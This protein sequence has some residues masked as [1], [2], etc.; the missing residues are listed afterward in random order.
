MNIPPSLIAGDAMS[1]T[2]VSFTRPDSSVV[3]SAAGWVLTYSLRGP[4][5]AGIDLPGVPQGTGWKFTLTA[6]QSAPFNTGSSPLTWYWQASATLGADR[7]TAGRGTLVVN[8]NL[9][10]IGVTDAFD[11]RSQAEVILAAID[12]E[13]AA[14]LNNGASIEYTI[15]TRSLKKEPMSELLKLRSE[16]LLRV[17]RERRAQAIAN[18]L[19]NP[20]TMGVRFK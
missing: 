8:P 7:A 5:G 18:G 3:S 13:I 4:I 17:S 1:W 20:S 6:A 11:G 19:G 2:D 15:G 14:R 12:S 9:A 10:G 16:Y